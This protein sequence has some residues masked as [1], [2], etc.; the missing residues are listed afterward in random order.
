MYVVGTAGHVDH[1]KSTLVRAL[2]GIDP[3]RLAEEQR[4]AMTIDLGFA[5]L[6]LPG[7]QPVS[8]VDVPG[9]ERFIKNMLAGVGG[10][11]AALLVIA[12]D[13]AVMP[14]TREHLAILDL[15]AVQHGVVVLTKC[16]LVDAEWLALVQAEVAATLAGTHLAHAPVVPVSAR[17][18]SGLDALLG[19]LE[20]VLAGV[21]TRD[22][23]AGVP[24]LP[25]D[26]AFT[27]GGF[28]TVVT[29]TLLDGSLHSGQEVLLLPAGTAARV[30]GLQNHNQPIA[31]ARPGHRIAVNLSGVHHSAIRRGDV[32]T[33]PNTLQPTTL[34]DVRLHLLPDLPRPLA[35]NA[36]LDLF[37]YAAVVPCRVALLEHE[38]LAAGAAG[39]AQLRL[40][41]PIAV[42]RG[43]RCIMRQ[44]ATNSTIGGGIIVD[45]HPPRHRRFRAEVLARLDLLQ[46][47][48]P[49]DLLLQALPR[50]GTR[51]WGDAS[52]SS[53]L[54]ADLAAQALATLLERQQVVVLTPTA[55]TPQ[56]L[57]ATAVLLRSEAWHSLQ[58]QIDSLLADYHR[59]Y[60]LR[61]GMPREELR[62]RTALDNR[63]FAA[64]LATLQQQQRVR[65]AGASLALPHHSR[66]P[67]AAQMQ[68]ADAF[69]AQ[70]A[71]TPYSPPAPDLDGEL[72]AWLQAQQQIVRVADVYFAPAALATMQQWVMDQIAQQGSIS[73]ADFRD[74]FGTTR[75]YA[76]AV[77][78]H[79]DEQKITR[80]EG[81]VRVLVG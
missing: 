9:H 8:I 51:T 47:G 7:G 54:P 11:D 45:T 79:L 52:A 63:A 26:R 49:P 14:Q 71:R 39:W 23:A 61:A 57:A 72:L 70:L 27:V 42:Q 68:A 41:H 73:V 64:V 66:T 37:V 21:P 24:R 20:R 4:R 76:L 40:A 56:A 55:P 36:A 31:Q 69:L 65:V 30:R 60:P 17:T 32:L 81:D 22:A 13:E 3:D 5:W 59:Q 67:D 44:P 18:G 48:D 62:Q 38:E 74:H 35:H 28:G 50:T 78:E 15:L 2:T 58:A 1:G 29:G 19:A 75:K 77:L 10:I 46:H 33:L 34:L 6:H 80:R 53:A 12:A 16:D 43:D 25:I